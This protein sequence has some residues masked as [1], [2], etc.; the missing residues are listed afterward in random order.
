MNK[1]FKRLPASSQR[2]GPRSIAL[3]AQLLRNR[4]LRNGPTRAQLAPQDAHRGPSVLRSDPRVVSRRDCSK[5]RELQVKRHDDI[6]APGDQ[7]TRPGLHFECRRRSSSRRALE[8]EQSPRECQFGSGQRRR[9]AGK[10]PQREQVPHCAAPNHT[11]DAL[12]KRRDPLVWSCSA[13][14]PGWSRRG[15]LL[16]RFQWPARLGTQTV[17]CRSFS[18]S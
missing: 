10:R 5:L 4:H 18:L 7:T 13:P 9:R 8:M 16:G 3:R 11:A 14:R 17:R 12:A 15:I 2:D 1:I 6:Q